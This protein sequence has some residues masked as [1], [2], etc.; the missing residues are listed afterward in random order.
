M[1]LSPLYSQSLLEDSLRPHLYQV[2]PSPFPSRNH[3]FTAF[4]KYL[5]SRFSFWVFWFVLVFLLSLRL[6]FITPSISDAKQLG[7]ALVMSAEAKGWGRALVASRGAPAGCGKM[8]QHRTSSHSVGNA[9]VPAP[10]AASLP[11]SPQF[12]KANPC[13]FS[14]HFVAFLVRTFLEVPS[15]P[16]YWCHF[17]SYLKLVPWEHLVRIP[18]LGGRVWMPKMRITLILCTWVT[19]KTLPIYRHTRTYV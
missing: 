16:F 12:R 17:I 19:F 4:F 5:F 13:H 8:Q 11:S 9:L 6:L 10:T 1:S 7:R 3:N 14:Q 18:V 2:W 15:L